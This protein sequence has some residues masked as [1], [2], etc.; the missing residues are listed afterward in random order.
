MNPHIPIDARLQLVSDTHVEIYWFQSNGFV[1]A[2]QG[3]PEGP[4]CAPLFRY[5][6]PSDDSIELIGSEGIIGTWTGLRIEGN[7]LHA[8][9]A[10]KAVAFRI[11]A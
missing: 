3:K 5:R 6:A 9:R 1:R 2:I 7:L 11:G 8:K 10:G 4:Q